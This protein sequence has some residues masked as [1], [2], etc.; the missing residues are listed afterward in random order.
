L[1][2]GLS[3]PILALISSTKSGNALGNFRDLLFAVSKAPAMLNFLNNQQNKKG[4]P[5]ENFAGK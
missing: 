2:A 1:Q 4:H 5:N 3:I